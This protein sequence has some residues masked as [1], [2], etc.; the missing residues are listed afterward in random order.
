MDL[1][2]SLFHVHDYLPISQTF[3]II[4]V[5]VIVSVILSYYKSSK[6]KL[7]VVKMDPNNDVIQ[8]WVEVGGAVLAL[9]GQKG[10][11]INIGQFGTSKNIYI[12]KNGHIA[13]HIS[14]DFFLELYRFNFIY[15]IQKNAVVYKSKGP[16]NANQAAG[17]AE[18]RDG[19]RE[20]ERERETRKI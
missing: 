15:E 1:I 8:R 10:N 13:Y 9:E 7:Y 18:Q 20:R 16:A 5:I 12:R 4:V 17:L 19:C 11:Q 14:D 2:L 3:E 6:N